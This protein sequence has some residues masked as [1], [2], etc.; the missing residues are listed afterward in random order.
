MSSTRPLITA[1]T[2]AP[3]CARSYTRNKKS[4]DM[5]R[6]KGGRRGANT[7]TLLYTSSTFILLS[8]QDG[9]LPSG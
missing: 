6:G 7:H 5:G 4:L 3:A 9:I 8:E 1:L 2:V